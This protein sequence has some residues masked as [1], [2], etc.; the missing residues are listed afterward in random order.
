MTIPKNERGVTLIELMITVAVASIVVG[1]MVQ[2]LYATNIV[3]IDQTSYSETQQN[4]RVSLALIKRYV[5]A[6]GWAVETSAT[7]EGAVPVGSCYNDASSAKMQFNCDGIDPD[8]ENSTGSPG[9]MDR[10]RLVAMQSVGGGGIFSQPYPSNQES[11]TTIKAGETVTAGPPAVVALSDHPFAIGELGVISGPCIGGATTPPAVGADLV[12]I[13]SVAVGGTSQFNY[14][15]T[16]I[17][18]GGSSFACTGAYDNGFHFG[19]ATVADFYIL[20]DPV[21]NRPAL[22]VRLDP[23]ANITTGS[24]TVAL[25]VDDLQIQYLIDAQCVGATCAGATTDNYWDTVCDNLQ[26]GAAGAFGCVAPGLTTARERAAR[27]LGVRI[28]LVVRTR[29]FDK[30]RNGVPAAPPFPEN[31]QLYNHVFKGRYDGYRRWVFR[32]TVS[33]RNTL[34]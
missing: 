29:K 21:T 22:K 11:A 26:S 31:I 7:S 2:I 20:R 9:G 24:Y 23:T 14:G 12:V 28:G 18:S 16:A 30:R 8:L 32:S 3:F 25:D 5:R 15:Y 34:L 6:A 10:M 19:R 27:I 33:V 17:E 13:D 1:G 4:A